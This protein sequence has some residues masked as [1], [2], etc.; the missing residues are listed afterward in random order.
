MFKHL[1][2]EDY[3]N[4]DGKYPKSN[5]PVSVKVYDDSIE[6]LFKNTT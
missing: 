4:R 5:I 1:N 3:Q 6:L 2:T